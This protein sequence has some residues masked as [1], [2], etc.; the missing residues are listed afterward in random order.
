MNFTLTDAVMVAVISACISFGAKLI[1]GYIARRKWPTEKRLTEADAAARLTGAAAGFVDDLRE[2]LRDQQKRIR[3]FE[4]YNRENDRTI[5]AQDQRIEQLIHD[6]LWAQQQI[7]KLEIANR[8]LKRDN[9]ALSE[10]VGR[11]R[12]I[13]TEAGIKNG[14]TNG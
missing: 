10:E 12:R 13:L 3:E 5:K 9:T 6:Q 2:Q 1:D 14:H 7:Q 11:L 4:E 8:Q